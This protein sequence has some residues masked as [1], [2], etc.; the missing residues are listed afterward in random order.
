MTDACA[1][2]LAC[3]PWLKEHE[4]PAERIERE[5]RD[6]EAL[7]NLLAREK[8]KT[9]WREIKYDQPPQLGLFL[10][11]SPDHPEHIVPVRADIYFGAIER[12]AQGGQPKHLSF[13]HFSHWLPMPLPHFSERGIRA[14][15]DF[16]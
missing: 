10:L 1:L 16:P 4:T 2:C 6:T 12:E 8:E 5:C 7:M 3:E 13:S 11:W 15:K 9:F 14:K